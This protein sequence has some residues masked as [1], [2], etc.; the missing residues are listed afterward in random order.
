MA[1]VAALLWNAY[2]DACSSGAA[3]GRGGVVSTSVEVES[4]DDVVVMEPSD[5][6]GN[7]EKKAE[8]FPNGVSLHTCQRLATLQEE[9]TSG[10][11]R[12]PDADREGAQLR[13]Q[14]LLR[15]LNAV[16]EHPDAPATF[17]A[18]SVAPQAWA[19]I[20]VA[21]DAMR[22]VPTALVSASVSC[23]SSVV[24]VECSVGVYLCVCVAA[25]LWLRLYLLC[26]GV[27]WAARRLPAVI[28]PD[29]GD[30]CAGTNGS[31]SILCS[32]HRHQ[33]APA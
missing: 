25:N 18:P 22:G 14:K 2:R 5:G 26:T 10:R 30:V 23:S 27:N 4:D 32:T 20:A 16:L 13:L 29:H 1:D 31:C 24:V 28:G 9:W 21:L 11:R 7:G 6:D 15:H 19:D 17:V 12:A 3:G 8:P 33:E